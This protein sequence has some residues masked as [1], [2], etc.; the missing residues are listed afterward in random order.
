M[1]ALKASS[2]CQ[3]ILYKAQSLGVPPIHQDLKDLSKKFLLVSKES[4]RK[5]WIPSDL[6]FDG[7][8]KQADVKFEFDGSGKRPEMRLA[9][10]LHKSNYKQIQIGTP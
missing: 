3:H 4:I 7:S 8:G 9:E 2:Y 5:R 6:R 10:A 1:R